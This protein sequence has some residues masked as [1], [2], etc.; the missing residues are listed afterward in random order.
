[1]YSTAHTKTRKIADPEKH[2]IYSLFYLF[3][4]LMFRRLLSNSLQL[5]DKI[6]RR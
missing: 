3:T 2:F 4:F 5:K 1:M 6:G